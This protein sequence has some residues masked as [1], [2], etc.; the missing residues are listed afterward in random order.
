MNDFG[1]ELVFVVANASS[2]LYLNA[3]RAVA[4]TLNQFAIPSNAVI[5]SCSDYN[6]YKYGLQARNT[7][8][9]RLSSS[10]IV[11]RFP[12]QRM[13]YLLGELDNDPAAA[14]LD[15]SCAAWMQGSH[16]LERGRIFGEYLRHFY[17]ASIS[18]NHRTIVVPGVG[19][20]AE[21]MF[22]SS[23]GVAH[24]FGAGE[25]DPVDVAPDLTGGAQ[26]LFL[27]QGHPNPFKSQT[28]TPTVLFSRWARESSRCR[29]SSS[30]RAL[31][32]PVR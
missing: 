12:Q 11:S 8:M 1:V 29:C 22:R 32:R 25:C 4:G 6:E 9:S 26:L 28:S 17:G 16:R 14:D 3:E 18:D 15:T 31:G 27:R 23:C 30:E 5:A 21:N 13:T 2:Y 19:H 7:Y 24:L 20:S 10:Q